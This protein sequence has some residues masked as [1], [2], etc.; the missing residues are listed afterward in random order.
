VAK[1]KSQQRQV[2]WQECKLQSMGCTE[3]VALKPAGGLVA[4]HKTQQKQVVWQECKTAIYLLH[5]ARSTYKP[6]GGL[7]AKHKTQ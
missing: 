6:V 4:K 2:V 3:R 1:H 5:G 7:V